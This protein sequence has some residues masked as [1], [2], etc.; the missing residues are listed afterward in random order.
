L[1]K[2]VACR[3]YDRNDARS[4]DKGGVRWGKCRRTGPI[5]HPDS[6]KVYLV[7]GIWPHVRDD[8]WC[9]EWTA[10]NR[11]VDSPATEA[12]NSLMMQSAAS[13][14]RPVPAAPAFAVP[15]PI[16]EPL[17]PPIS[18]LMRGPFGSD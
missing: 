13:T 12:M 5:V 15:E 1:H 16:G 11:H 2:C 14:A 18:T 10:N 9:G 17:H 8:D 3:F 7:E 4:D 6:A